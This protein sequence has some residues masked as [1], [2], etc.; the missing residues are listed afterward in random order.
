LKKVVTAVSQISIPILPVKTVLFPG[1]VVRLQVVETRHRALV[2]AAVSHYQRRFGVS[3][4]RLGEG[5]AE[6][7]GLCPI[8][9]IAQILHLTREKDAHV[10]LI[11]LGKERFR[12]VSFDPSG[13]YPVAVVEDAPLRAVAS[14]Q[15]HALERQARTIAT[16]YFSLLLNLSEGDSDRLKL[17]AAAVPLANFIAANVQISL[18]RRQHLLEFNELEILLGQEI[19]LLERELKRIQWFEA[20]KRLRPKGPAPF[21]LN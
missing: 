6:A 14:P 11:A 3:L 19:Q 15:I 21:S 17:P 16:E 8:G 4:M 10:N 2:D 18:D 7:A 5:P 12:V 20:Q 1:T 13:A 9:T